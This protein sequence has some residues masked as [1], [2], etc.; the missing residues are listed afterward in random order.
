MMKKSFLWGITP[1]A[2][3]FIPA[4]GSR[5]L[6]MEQTAYQPIR[7]SFDRLAPSEQTANVES[8]RQRMARRRTV[9]QYSSEE[10]PQ[11]LIDG[12]I[13]VAGTAASGTNLQPWQFV[14]VR[15]PTSN[16]G[17]AMPPNR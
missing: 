3:P 17:F 15:D 6:L 11:A 10:V 8:F 14:V 7:L 4:D 1:A 9:C 12:A 2:P 13:A 16:G 5:G